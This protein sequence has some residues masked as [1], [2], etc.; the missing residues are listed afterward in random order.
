MPA[1]LSVI[2]WLAAVEVALRITSVS[3]LSRLL[4]VPIDTTDTCSG[5]TEPPPQALTAGERRRL[6]ILAAAVTRWPFGRGP[7]LRQSLVAGRILVRHQP[8]LRLGAA[9]IEGGV[10]GHAW[11]ELDGDRSVGRPSGFP[12]LL[13]HS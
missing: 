3:R 10:V 5:R 7:C 4:G 6:R 8:R 2:G 11:L 13:T 1:G 12:V 9:P